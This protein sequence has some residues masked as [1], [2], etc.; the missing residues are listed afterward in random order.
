MFLMKI[1]FVN[2][3]FFADIYVAAASHLDIVVDYLVN[4]DAP[5]A[6]STR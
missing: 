2:Y 1:H 4:A 5:A 3:Y 6:K